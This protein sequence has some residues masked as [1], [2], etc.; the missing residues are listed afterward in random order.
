MLDHSTGAP[1]VVACGPFT[2]LWQVKRRWLFQLLFSPFAC[3]AYTVSVPFAMGSAFGVAPAHLGRWKLG[4][5]LGAG[6][7]FNCAIP[8]RPYNS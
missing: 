6:G 4:K 5:P 7:L 8:I 1:G 2:Y 3:L